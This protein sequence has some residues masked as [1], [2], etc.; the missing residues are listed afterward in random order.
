MADGLVFSYESSTQHQSSDLHADQGF[1]SSSIV[2]EQDGA[3]GAYLPNI[4]RD[5]MKRVIHTLVQSS[6]TVCC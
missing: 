5:V 2:A 1:V 6:E 4:V 3:H